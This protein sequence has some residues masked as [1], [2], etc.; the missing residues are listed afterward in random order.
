MTSRFNDEIY[1]EVI[2]GL[3]SIDEVELLA[4]EEKA[5]NESKTALTSNSALVVPTLAAYTFFCWAPLAGYKVLGMSHPGFT[6]NPAFRELAV[7]LII[8][9]P[10][11][12]LA[13]SQY[14][15]ARSY[16][17]HLKRAKGDISTSNYNM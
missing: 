5:R 12:L 3:E 10:L 11:A 15:F 9:I 8:H 4:L 2:D 16:R 13:L 1:Q 14:F 7:Q 17:Y 6:R